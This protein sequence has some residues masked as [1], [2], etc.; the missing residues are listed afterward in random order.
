M[1]SE[2]SPKITLTSTINSGHVMPVLDA[3]TMDVPQDIRAFETAS[4]ENASVYGESQGR[5]LSIEEMVALKIAALKVVQDFNR[6]LAD[7][8]LSNETLE[9][10]KIIYIYNYI[11]GNVKYAD[12]LSANDGTGRVQNR[13]E[14]M[15]T[16][17]ESAYTAL[18]LKKSI[19]CGISD[20]V[21]L[22][23][24]I[25]GLECEK[26]LVPNGGHAYNKVKV[27][28]LWYKVDA[29][30]PIGFY[31]N[32]KAEEWNINYFLTATEQPFQTLN[33][34]RLENYPRD[35]IRLVK[36]LLECCGFNFN[37]SSSLKITIKTPMDG[38]KTLIN[39]AN[40]ILDKQPCLVNLSHIISEV[41]KSTNST[42]LITILNR[43]DKP[44][45]SREKEKIF[46]TPDDKKITILSTNY[47]INI[48]AFNDNFAINTVTLD[49]SQKTYVT[50]N[51]GNII[52]LL[53]RGSSIIE[54]SPYLGTR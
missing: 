38:L 39:D 21:Y 4:F 49:G 3:I 20:T 13:P 37:Y 9:L 48:I 12:V 5:A 29:T 16:P 41:D 40:Q 31:P 17:Y 53:G 2:N 1:S 45:S 10:A 34:E 18:V 19:C 32:A 43:S 36:T 44:E 47:R 35:R 25:M 15:C 27:G 22:L 24:K 54:S 50:D 8:R 46:Y 7:I 6:A 11:L 51:K 30:F 14:D 28:N 23:C 33:Y 42:P 26:W 52:G